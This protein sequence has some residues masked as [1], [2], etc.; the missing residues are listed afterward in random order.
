MIT[1]HNTKQLEIIFL[2]FRWKIDYVLST[3][4]INEEN[5]SV[6]YTMTDLKPYTDYA[7]YVSTYSLSIEKQGAQS[8]LTYFRTRPDSKFFE[9]S[10]R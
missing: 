2:K 10:T 7:F 5:Q 8:S 4:H 3:N 1:Y 9:N 6:K